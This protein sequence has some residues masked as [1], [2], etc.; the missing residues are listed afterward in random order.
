MFMSQNA[1][2]KISDIN[3]TMHATSPNQTNLKLYA[4]ESHQT[5][6]QNPIKIYKP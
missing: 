6:P 4:T 3:T 5:M 2:L 1:G